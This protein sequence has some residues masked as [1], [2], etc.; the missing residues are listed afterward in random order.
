MPDG[1][2]GTGIIYRSI[3]DPNDRGKVVAMEILEFLDNGVAAKAGWKAGT[4]IELEERKTIAEVRNE[5]RSRDYSNMK[6]INGKSDLIDK[7]KN[8]ANSKKD[9]P[10]FYIKDKD[11]KYKHAKYQQVKEEFAKRQ[12]SQSLG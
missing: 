1:I 5:V 12:A 4:R 11:G 7:I 2:S 6:S 3:L 8:L 10:D 9:D